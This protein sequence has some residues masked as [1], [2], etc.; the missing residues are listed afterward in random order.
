MEV[1]LTRCLLLLEAKL[2]DKRKATKLLRLLKDK[3]VEG[4]AQGAMVTHVA[5]SG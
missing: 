1:R 2:G 3:R 5:F 4:E